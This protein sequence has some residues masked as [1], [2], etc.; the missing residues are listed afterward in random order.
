MQA[1][2]GVYCDTTRLA[3]LSSAGGFY[4]AALIRVMEWA[5][6]EHSN[7]ASNVTSDFRWSVTLSGSWNEFSV[8]MLG[9]LIS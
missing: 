3:C 8:S 7:V 1:L 4:M 9:P 2:D 6:K 5:G